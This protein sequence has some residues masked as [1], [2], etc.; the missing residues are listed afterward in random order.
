MMS[1]TKQ[2]ERKAEWIPEAVQGQWRAESIGTWSKKKQDN[3]NLIRAELTRALHFPMSMGSLKYRQ[4]V[5]T[6]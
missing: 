2:K 3:E 4:K 5:F 1:P 6:E